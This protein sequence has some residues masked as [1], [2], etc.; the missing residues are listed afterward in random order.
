MKEARIRRLMKLKKSA[1]QSTDGILSTHP[2]N[3]ETRDMKRRTTIE[4]SQIDDGKYNLQF[5]N[6]KYKPPEGYRESSSLSTRYVPNMPGVQAQRVPGTSN[7]FKDPHSGKVFDYNEGF[8]ED[9]VVY[10]PQGVQY[11]TSHMNSLASQAS[12]SLRSSKLYKESRI[13]DVLF[14]K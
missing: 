4:N 10:N 1:Q 6:K 8:S 2:V 7:V 3:L 5:D 9:N 11:Q 14:K 12:D 13:I